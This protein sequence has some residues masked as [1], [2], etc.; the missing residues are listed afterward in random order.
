M[1]FAV[2]EEDE[3]VFFNEQ[4]LLPDR[5]IGIVIPS[6]VDRRL[7][8]IIQGC[9]HDTAKGDLLS[10]LFRDGGALGSLQTRVQVGFAIGL[11]GEDIF[12]DLKRIVKIRNAYAHQPGAR[13]FKTQPICDFTRDFVLP[14]RHPKET[15]ATPETDTR[16]QRIERLM[17][18]SGLIDLKPLR[19][20]YLR[21]T[22]I[23]LTWLSIKSGHFDLPPP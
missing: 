19:H 20:R 8:L 18:A 13:D 16:E 22:E 3:K 10:E 7:A 9:W 15:S 21:T 4:S 6:L 12:A 11:Y 17:R 5:V 23:I 14:E 1:P 2:I